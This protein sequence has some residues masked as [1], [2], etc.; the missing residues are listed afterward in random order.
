MVE[1]EQ[2]LRRR[3]A[4]RALA[5]EHPHQVRLDLDR[6][7]AV[8]VRRLADGDHELAGLVEAGRVERE[9][10]E[11]LRRFARGE[12]FDGQPMPGL[13]SEALDFRAASESFAT[14][15]KMRRRDLDTLRLVTEHQGQR[16]PTVGGML[17]FGKDRER[18]LPG[19]WVQAGRFR[20]SDESRIAD[21]FEIRSFSIR[22]IEEAIAFVEK[23]SLHGPRLGPYAARI[24]LT[25][26]A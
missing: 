17:L 12:A 8:R 1:R 7:R 11:E 13:D 18:H 15:R 20:G 14:L 25:P 10:V 5:A 2:D 22:A 23:H 4:E 9:L 6:G 19:A 21:R 24:G 16:V 3:G 26:R